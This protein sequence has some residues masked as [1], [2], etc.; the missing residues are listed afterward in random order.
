M[1]GKA[2]KQKQTK[3]TNPL[4]VANKKVFGKGNVAHPR[5]LTRYVKYPLYVRIQKE[6]RLL[7]KRLKTPPAV[8]IFA[9]H[10]LDKT[11]A[12]Q[13]FKILDHIKPEERAAKLQR[14]RAA[15]KELA[16]KTQ[17][18]EKATASKKTEKP[19]TLSYGINN[20]VRLIE[21]KQAKLVVIAHDV[22]PLE[23]VVY[24][25]YLCKKLQVPYCIVKGKARLGQL[26]HRPTAAV[27]A[28]TETKKEDKA[29]FESLVQNVKSIYFENAHMYREF[30]GRINGFKHNEKQ[31]KIQNKL[32]KDLAD[33][34]KQQA[35]LTVT[36]AVEEKAAPVA[37][38]KKADKTA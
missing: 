36:T 13:L 25:P 29:A 22:E 5:D 11:N 30:G 18:G 33:K 6:K 10:T 24:L 14:I 1:S 32:N 28:V 3:Q 26:I 9:N 16:E 7:M 31:K 15:A 37:E 2:N 35:A 23:M 27:V 19:A 38:E 12:T 20:V 34:A 21:R 17:K 8:N 4:I